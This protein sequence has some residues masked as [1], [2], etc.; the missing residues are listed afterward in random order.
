[1]K[2]DIIIL[3]GGPGGYVAAIYAAK[4]GRK[5]ALIEQDKLGGTCL[6]RGCIPTKALLESA[7]VLK[8]VKTSEIFGI[9]A[10]TPQTNWTAV[11]ERKVQVVETLRN[12][13]AGLMT[14]NGVEVY[15]ARGKITGKHSVAVELESGCEFL[16]GENII[17]ATGSV[18]ASIPVPGVELPGVI[19]SDECLELEEIPDSLAIVGG[20][21]IGLEM[22]YVFA[23]FGAKVT[24][25]EMLPELLGGKQDK[26]VANMMKRQF[27]TLGVTTNL[28]AK[29]EKIEL[30]DGK[31]QVSFEMKGKENTVAV[32]KVLM[33]T[34]RRAV[35]DFYEGIELNIERNFI[36]VDDH[37][38]TN[39]PN[40]YAIGDVT[41]KIMLAHVASHQGIT[42]VNNI[43]GEDETMDYSAVPSCLYTT[44]ES[45]S[46]GMTEKEAREV[47]GDKVITA[48]FPFAAI[49]KALILNQSQG[50]VKIIAE[51]D[52]KQILGVHIVGP[53][54]TE[55]ITE[56]VYVIKHKGTL[57]DVADTIHAHPTLSESLME[58]CQMARGTAIHC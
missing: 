54:A 1:M 21:V 43:L 24:I 48:M 56:M 45:S 5:V 47:F 2:Y 26:D 53:R 58:A 49:G 37:M 6:N 57:D 30:A 27:K 50:F 9:H 42:A 16:E 52:A 3:G 28:K 51:S 32:D 12:G 29:L 46:V 19:T 25:L 38:R 34:G 33:A 35:L 14:Q 39:I 17:I 22:G 44:P 31:L 18:P 4:K 13:V 40:I 15:N 20:G 23:S 11:M 41:G 7:E 55:L 10:G 36:V 8:T